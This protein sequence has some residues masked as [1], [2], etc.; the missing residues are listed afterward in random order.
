MNASDY[1]QLS[2]AVIAG[3]G[4]IFAFL[5]IKNSNKQINLQQKQWEHSY[6][7]VFYISYI[8]SFDNKSY[9]FVIENTNRVSHQIEQVSFSSKD[10]KIKTDFNGFIESKSEKKGVITEKREY[11]GLIITLSVTENLYQNGTI[12]IKGRDSLG[13][14]FKANSNEIVFKNYLLENHLKISRTYLKNI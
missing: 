2:L 3:V 6:V 14:Q 1:I 12:Q 10:V 9:S 5:N 4:A 13:N 11:H 8:T 7:P